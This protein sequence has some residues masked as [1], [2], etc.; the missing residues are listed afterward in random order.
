MNNEKCDCV[1]DNYVT[2][3]RFGEIKGRAKRGKSI[4]IT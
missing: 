3:K 4:R 2:V 1:V